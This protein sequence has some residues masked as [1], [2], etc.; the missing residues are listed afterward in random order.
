MSSSHPDTRAMKICPPPPVTRSF[1]SL[2][3][4]R[5]PLFLP[6]FCRIAKT[7]SLTKNRIWLNLEEKDAKYTEKAAIFFHLNLSLLLFPYFT[8]AK[9]FSLFRRSPHLCKSRA[10]RSQEARACK[11]FFGERLRLSFTIAQGIAVST[12]GRD[13]LIRPAPSCRG[14]ATLRSDSRSDHHSP[15][16]RSFTAHK[17]KPPPFPLRQA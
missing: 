14:S 6:D 15:S 9:T 1:P 17:R 4:P 12:A 3:K 10:A 8:D 5:F 7:F 16:V 2:R 11:A 13:I